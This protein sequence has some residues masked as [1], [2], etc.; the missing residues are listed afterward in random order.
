MTFPPE[1]FPDSILT[2][3]IGE[4]TTETK[5]I[6]E[7][8]TSPSLTMSIDGITNNAIHFEVENMPLSTPNITYRTSIPI[9]LDLIA[10]CPDD[11]GYEIFTKIEQSEY[12]QSTFPIFVLF[13]SSFDPIQQT[14]T[15]EL[16]PEMFEN[17]SADIILSW[18]CLYK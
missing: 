9:P 10:Q 2:I 14:L 16:H 6:F 1:A 11:Y 4:A 15:T 7:D 3:T 8:T 5:A 18:Y 17:F 12:P 13:P